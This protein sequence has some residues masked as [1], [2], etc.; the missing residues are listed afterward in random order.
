M[1]ASVGERVIRWSPAQAEPPRPGSAAVG[2][3]SGSAVAEKR[4]AHQV[5][6]SMSAAEIT[7]SHAVSM[8]SA[9]AR[10]NDG[11]VKAPSVTCPT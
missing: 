8:W 4:R 10:V 9:K 7:S 6:S 1:P 2:L 3:R 5:A 11:P